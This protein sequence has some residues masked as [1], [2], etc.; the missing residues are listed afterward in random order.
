M[1]DWNDLRYLLA[2]A[3]EGSTLAA[4]KALGV[5]QPTVQRRLA[6]L[7][8]RIG[9]KLVELHPTGYRLTE[10]GKVLFP[11]A[12]DV[13]RAVDAF[14]RQVM[15]AGEELT[16]TLRVT[17]PE[18]LASRLLAPMIEAFR[19]KH[20]ELRIDLIM[21]D[22]RLDLAKG[23]AEVALR[24]HEP[25]D[26]SFIARRIAN[27]PWAIFASQ[28]YIRRHGRPERPED[29]DHHAI[30]EFAGEL[31]GNHAGRWLRA[32]APKA[33]IAVRG[34]SMLGVLAAVRSGSGLAPLPM[35]LGASEDG[36]VPVLTSIPDIDSKLYLVMHADLQHTPRVRAF[37][38]FVIAEFAR[39][40][41][42]LKGDVKAP[43]RPFE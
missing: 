2:I 13:E 29:L 34:N 27:S 6:A 9:R 17:C 19:D 18:G 41:P 24:M 31:A 5:S 3:R 28:S 12:V 23:E 40:R 30:V 8:E 36:L 16:G 14:Q 42:R 37:C 10:L 32:V 26:D 38:D 22:R 25:G 7:E 11:H 4:A 1:F 21:T 35:L 43:D 20:P 39:L 33:A 15:S